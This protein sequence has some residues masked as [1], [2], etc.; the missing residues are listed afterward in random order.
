[1]DIKAIFF[2]LDDTLHDHQK[3]FSD[4]IG[5]MFKNSYRDIAIDS[6]YKKFRECSDI[7]WR[8]YSNRELTLEELRIQRITLAL[9]SF[10]INL[11]N[12]QAS[13]FQNQYQF[14]LS[15]L[16]LFA[17]VPEILE[18][19]NH[20][21]Y[22]LGIITNGPIDHQFNKI[23]TLG[24]IK[25]IR[26][27]LIFIS[28]EVGVAKPNPEIFNYVAKKVNFAPEELLYIGDTWTN[29]IVGAYEAGWQSIWYN[30]RKRLPETELKP[31]AEIDCLSSLIQVL[32]KNP[33]LI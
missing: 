22:V 16:E 27:E 17:Q 9:K 31:L 6:V 25:Y 7:L 19:L 26:R 28:D 30:H 5:E 14:C 33:S 11:S 13:Q 12:E 1:M 21:G 24:L 32:Q 8:N 18:V 2:D 4:A 10:G 29:D 3:P 20:N 15:N 23:K